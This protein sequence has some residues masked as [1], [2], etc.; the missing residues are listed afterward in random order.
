MF[1]LTPQKSVL[2]VYINIQMSV[3]KVYIDIQISVLNVYT[4]TPEISFKCLY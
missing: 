1:I 2:N 4:D 3:L